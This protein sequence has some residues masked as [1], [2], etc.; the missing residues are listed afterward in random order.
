MTSSVGKFRRQPLSLAFGSFNVN[1]FGINI[2]DSLLNNKEWIVLELDLPYFQV[3]AKENDP[4]E[5]R[6][7]RLV[8]LCG[9]NKPNR[10][11]IGIKHWP[12]AT[13]PL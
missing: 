12:E 4:K 9:E 2:F 8:G 11:S 5:S 10:A 13:R 1:A 6:E 3:N 7:L